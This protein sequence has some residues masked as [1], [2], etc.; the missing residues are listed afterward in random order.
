MISSPLLRCCSLIDNVSGITIIILYWRGVCAC[1]CMCLYVSH[2]PGRRRNPFLACTCLRRFRPHENATT[3]DAFHPFGLGT[4]LSGNNGKRIPTPS[5]TIPDAESPI[6]MQQWVRKCWC[7]CFLSVR[8]HYFR[9]ASEL[10]VVP[11]SRVRGRMSVC[12][13]VLFIFCFFPV[14]QLAPSSHRSHTRSGCCI[15]VYI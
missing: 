4:Q 3:G 5:A 6:V 15:H 13:C 8:Y 1:D 11:S 2:Q 10:P 14:K 7:C 9:D 12:V